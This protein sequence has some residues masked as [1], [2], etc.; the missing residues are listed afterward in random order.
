VVI[1][2]DPARIRNW[3]I[4]QI[5][6]SDLFG[7]DSAR[8]P[9]VDDLMDER[10]MI[11]AQSELSKED[12][13]RLREIEDE[14]GDLPTGETPDDIEAMNLIRRAAKRLQKEES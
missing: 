3:R 14:L 8:P 12:E 4:D 11:L 13:E 7:L 5:L 10:E 6:T 2:N 9:Q 1:D